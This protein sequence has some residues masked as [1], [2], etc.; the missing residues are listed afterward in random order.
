[1]A[2]YKVSEEAKA[3]IA[4]MYEYGIETFGL[5]QAQDYFMQLHDLFEKLAQNDSLGREASEYK[6]Y[7]KRY[8]FKSHS[9]F[10]MAMDTHVFIV[11]ILGQKQ[12]FGLHL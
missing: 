5:Q 9:I 12:N 2:A 8:N 11:R 7:L 10:Y 3:D 4:E 6:P 1:M